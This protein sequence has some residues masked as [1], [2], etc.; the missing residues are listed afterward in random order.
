MKRFLFL[1]FYSLML[2]TQAQIS[3][4][5][6]NNEEIVMYQVNVRA[7]SE[8]GDI[9]GVINKL[10]HIKD[11][12]TNV[13]Y[14]MPLFVSDQSPYA[15][16]NYA[17]IDPEYGTKED[18]SRLIDLAHE[19]D[20][21]VI[22]D[23]AVN[24]TGTSHVW[25]DDP[26][27]SHWWYQQAHN[28][29]EQGVHGPPPAHP[30]WT[31]VYQLDFDNADLRDSLIQTM[32]YWVNTS[33]C[34]GFRFD[35]TD[36][37]DVMLNDG[38]SDPSKFNF[39]FW[40][41]VI[42]ELR[43][44]PK[45]LL[46]LAEGDGNE[47]FNLDFDL[48][49][50]NAL[51]YEF[52]NW[53]FNTEQPNSSVAASLNY[54]N[55]FDYGATNGQLP[56]RFTANHDT[57]AHYGTPSQLFGGETGQLA[58]FVVAAYMRGVPMIFSGQEV[59]T[60]TQVPFYTKGVNGTINWNGLNG[61]IHT[62]YK[63][64]IT[65]R[66][67][68]DAIKYG[69]LTDFSNDDICAFTK[70]YN[71]EEILIVANL[72]SSNKAITIPVA[73]Q[74]NWKEAFTNEPTTIGANQSLNAFEYKVYR[75]G[76]IITSLDKALGSFDIYPNPSKDEINIIS[77]QEIVAATVINLQGQEILHSNQKAINI[78]SLQQ[79]VYLLQVDFENGSIMKQF[80]KE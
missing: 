40:K 26:I 48:T 20:M 46:L 33:N 37:P 43:K 63:E 45:D 61:D 79:G 70:K 60:P 49:Y 77:S 64:I 30:G 80:I 2:S 67:N 23:L 51:F 31:D 4:L 28:T 10:D 53:V 39:Q 27:Y 25:L 47:Y 17:A 29:G 66:K 1:I 78:S 72:K 62:K 16:N 50:G 56:V 54:A 8:N 65:L 44:H 55:G 73:A 14:L 9:E 7:F 12:G 21:A 35:Y 6:V 38:D 24:H 71:N 15:T 5:P 59:N 36:G 58:A 19:K 74:G 41:Q 76:H 57:H 52:K 22:L 11:L 68:S 42:T 3:W 13:I 32:I 18:L 75:R 69:S 34:D